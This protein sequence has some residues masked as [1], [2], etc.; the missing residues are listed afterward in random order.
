MTF[1]I[2]ILY[3]VKE[4]VSAHENNV[5]LQISVQPDICCHC[6]ADICMQTMQQCNVGTDYGSVLCCVCC[7]AILNY[8]SDVIID[9][10][11]EYD[12]HVVAS[13]LSAVDSMFELYSHLLQYC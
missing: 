11:E 5:V 1:D 12:P 8:G 9:C 10:P 2:Y 3:L 7:Q 13:T 4:T 6:C